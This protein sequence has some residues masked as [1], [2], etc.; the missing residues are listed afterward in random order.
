MDQKHYSA[1]III[2]HWLMGIALIGMIGVGLVMAADIIPKEL[3]GTVYGI[4]K[5]TGIIL[6]LLVIVRLGIRMVSK[7]P[8]L[9]GSIPSLEAITAK[10]G[11]YALYVM[12]F[13]LPLSGWV[14]SSAGGHP[15]S[16]YGLFEWPGFPG[17]GGNKE[18]GGIAHEIHE[19]GGWVLIGLISVHAAAVIFHLV[20]E[21]VN[22]LPRMW[23][24]GKSE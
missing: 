6:L 9:P 13:A 11:H 12:M 10:L 20:K 4:H 5:A 8:A 7:L 22:L 14:M 19:Y 17:V 3:R 15:I 16:I 24:A 18:I 2:L 21:K 23:F 1:P